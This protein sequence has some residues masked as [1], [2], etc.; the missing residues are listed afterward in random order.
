[1]REHKLQPADIARV[2][3]HVHQGAIDVLGPVVESADRAPGEVLD[4]HRARR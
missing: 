2:T 3:A 4:G 1:M